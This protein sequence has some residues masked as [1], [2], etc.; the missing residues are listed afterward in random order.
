MLDADEAYF[1]EHGEP[2]F[3]SH[4]LDLSEESKEENIADC[5][6]YFSRMAKMNQ[7]LEME[8]GITGGEEDGV[9]NTG[10]D[11]ASLYTQPED[12]YDVYAALSKI[13]PNFSI[14]AGFGNVHGVYKPGNV[15]LRPDI[16]G[17]HQ[18]YTKE[19]IGGSDKPLYLVFHGGSGS[20]KEEIR[21]AVVNGVVKMNVD[22]DTQWAYLTGIRDY[23]LK[24]KDYIMSQVGNPDGP[25]KPNKKYYDPRV[26]VREG[27]K[28]L[29]TRVKEACVD[30]GNEN[31]N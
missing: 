25:D 15:K 9:D 8:I 31:R 16:L 21:E 12:I 5:V 11:N 26:W 2:L 1:K 29:Y 4:M 7:W 19:K 10:V 30:L 3:S 27:E 22:T 24:K 6:K 28:T 18:E 13:S 17:K 20:S 23:V 14:A